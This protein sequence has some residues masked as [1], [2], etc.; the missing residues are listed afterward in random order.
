MGLTVIFT[1]A[2]FFIGAPLRLLG[3]F[4]FDRARGKPAT[5]DIGV[6]PFKTRVI[7]PKDLEVEKNKKDSPYDYSVDMS[8]LKPTEVPVVILSGGV[9]VVGKSLILWVTAYVGIKFI[10]FKIFPDFP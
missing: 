5:L 1:Y 2:D 7:G 6:G 10:H 8:S 9:K 3:G 4:I